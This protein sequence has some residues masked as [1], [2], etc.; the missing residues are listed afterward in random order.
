MVNGVH[1]SYVVLY[2]AAPDRTTDFQGDF[3]S[4]TIA[5]TTLSSTHF[6]ADTRKVHH[7]L[8]DYL[9]ADTD[10]QWIRSIEKR[11]SGQ[12]DFTALCRHYSGE[13]NVI[14]RVATAD[15]IQETLTYK[16][17]HVLSFNTFLYRMQ[18]IFNI[19]CNKGEHMDNRT[20]VR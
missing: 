2:Q 13:G 3:I 18:K 17:E 15:F 19:F 7:P 10:E 16:S 4:E 8:K 11:V 5:C 12:D 6:Q 14:H 20:Q 1:L 9:V